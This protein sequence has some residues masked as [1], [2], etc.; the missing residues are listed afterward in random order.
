MEAIKLSF[1]LLEQEVFTTLET[2]SWL[3]TLFC[4]LA[5]AYVAVFF[6]VTFFIPISFFVLFFLAP[7]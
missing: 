2:T 6:F 4:I 3:D 7:F 1:D 5:Y